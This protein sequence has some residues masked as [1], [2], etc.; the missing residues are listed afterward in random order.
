M[1]Q[2]HKHCDYCWYASEVCLIWAPCLH[3]PLHHKQHCKYC[4][5]ASEVALIWMPCRHTPQHHKHCKYCQCASE[6]GLIWVM[7]RCQ[8]VFFR[9]CFFGA[10]TLARL[11][12][13]AYTRR[14]ITSVEVLPVCIR[15]GPHVGALQG[16]RQVQCGGCT[17]CPRLPCSGP[18]LCPRA[19]QVC[20][21]HTATKTTAAYSTLLCSRP[22]S[23]EVV[24]I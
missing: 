18:S 6:M 12:R 24:L 17:F 7:L 3:V 14:S 4:Q 2:H 20:C 15:S 10:Q 19:T 22:V 16:L 9:T 23:S 13:L 8:G 11:L 21:M 1:P 5:C